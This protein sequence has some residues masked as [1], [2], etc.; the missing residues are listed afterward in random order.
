MPPFLLTTSLFFSA[1]VLLGLLLIRIHRRK[2]AGLRYQ[3]DLA[4]RAANLAFS[5][6]DE[7]IR[8]ANEATKESIHLRMTRSGVSRELANQ[9]NSQ[10]MLRDQRNRMFIER[11]EARLRVQT[12]EA[13]NAKL[14]GL[15][16]AKRKRSVKIK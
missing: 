16:V 9:L 14:E 5:D 1:F 10:R 2:L 13:L 8:R 11:N 6:R 7:A 4:L 15:L 3:R 12:L